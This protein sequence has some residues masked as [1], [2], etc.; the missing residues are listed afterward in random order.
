MK[1]IAINEFGG[2]DKLQL[3]DLPVPEYGPEEMLVKVRAAG[4]N[5]VDWKIRE[6]Y[7]N[8]LFPHEFPVI[9]GWDAAGTVERVGQRVSRFKEGDEIFAYCRKPMVHGGSYA[10]FIVLQEEHTALKPKNISFEEA[11]SIPLAALTAFQALFDGANLTSQETVLIHAAAGGVGSFAVQLAKERGA[12]VLGTASAHNEEYVRNLGARQV[13]DYTQKN[14]VQVVH[15]QFSDGVDVVFDCVGGEV[16]EQ[17][18]EILKQGGRL[19]S[20]VDDPSGIARSDI[21]TEFV[22]VAPNSTQLKE[23]ALMTEQGRLSTHL[24]QTFPFGLEEARKAHELSESGHTR[25]KM[26]LVL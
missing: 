9:L 11:A 5:P 13:I 7:L 10:D 1:A 20:I 12:V 3:M 14:F 24:S 19:I 8:D 15:D 2:R 23:L 18:A 26:V 21:H 6:G 4:V 16:L 17:S 25:G 22:F